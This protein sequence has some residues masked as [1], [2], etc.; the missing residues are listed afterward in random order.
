[1][2]GCGP[3]VAVRRY[4]RYD[5]LHF[6]H[7]F[8]HIYGSCL[9]SPHTYFSSGPIHYM[10]T[11]VSDILVTILDDLVYAWLLYYLISVQSTFEV[12]M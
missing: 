10:I 5:A 9:L 6:I 8:S 2:N 4:I 3:V 7:T 1:M 12:G 11:V